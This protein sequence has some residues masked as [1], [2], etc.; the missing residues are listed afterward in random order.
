MGSFCSDCCL[1]EK[2]V[3]VS[4]L[5]F[6]LLSPVMEVWGF[7]GRVVLSNSS[8]QTELRKSKWPKGTITKG[9]NDTPNSGRK[10]RGNVACRYR[11]TDLNFISNDSLEHQ[12]LDGV[13]TSLLHTD[14]Q[15]ATNHCTQ[16]YSSKSWLVWFV[17]CFKEKAGHLRLLQSFYLQQWSQTLGLFLPKHLSPIASRTVRR[18]LGLHSEPNVHGSC[19]DP[20]KVYNCWTC[21]AFPPVLSIQHYLNRSCTRQ[22]AIN[23]KETMQKENF[24]T[25]TKDKRALHETADFL[26]KYLANQKAK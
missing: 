23:T 1:S 8:C 6:D 13:R 5:W 11:C 12:P 2:E 25:K 16:L 4:R 22:T 19:S 3:F 26:D 21:S 10:S 24:E 7:Y 9:K 14:E 17:L 18:R 15:L 20:A